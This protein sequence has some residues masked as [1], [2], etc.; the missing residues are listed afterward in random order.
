MNYLARVALGAAHA[1]DDYRPVLWA[2]LHAMEVAG[3]QV[4]GFHSQARFVESDGTL[5]I[6]GRAERHLDSWLMS[7]DHCREVV[8]HGMRGADLAVVEGSF[9]TSQGGGLDALCDWLDLPRWM[10]A[11]ASSADPCRTPLRPDKVDGVFL[12]GLRDERELVR[13]ALRWETLWG[14]P[15]LGGLAN[16]PHVLAILEHLPRGARPSRELCRALGESLI[17]R[18]DIDTLLSLANRPWHDPTPQLFRPAPRMSGLTVAVAFDGA[19]HGYFPDTL[20]LMELSGAKL[21]D[22]SPLH[23]EELPAGADIVLLGGGY[24]ERVA[25]SLASNQC[26]M[27]ALRRH[28]RDG[29]RVYAEAGGAAYLCHQMEL[30]DG[31]RWP[32]CG[33]LPAIARASRNAPPPTPAAITLS[34][35]CYLGQRG[36][37]LRGYR[38]SPWRLE[39]LDTMETLAQE[40]AA[41]FDLVRHRNVIAGQLHLSLVAQPHLLQTFLAAPSHS[42]AT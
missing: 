34:S 10:V 25:E 26:M 15:V 31:S 4:Q 28:V 33:L 8:S 3:I 13:Q 21:V 22:F 39:P 42:T 27:M 2:L 29:G 23:D 19:F 1:H 30:A 18:K 5:A 37:C 11:D 7:P 12:A 41:R 24:P 16:C 6:S 32:M 35:D 36:D 17:L 38:T 40:P 14:V 20:D 9:V